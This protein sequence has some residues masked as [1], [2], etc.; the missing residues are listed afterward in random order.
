[1]GIRGTPASFVNGRYLGGAQSAEALDET[2]AREREAAQALVDAG[3]P[4]GA[5]L[6]QLLPKSEG[7]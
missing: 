4:P 6:D 5:V 3:T 7:S 1:V 2:I